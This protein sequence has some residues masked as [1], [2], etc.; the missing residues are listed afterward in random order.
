MLSRRS[1]DELRLWVL[2]RLCPAF[3]AAAEI[4]LDYFRMGPD[5]GGTTAG[6]ALAVVEHRNTITGRH[7]HIHVMFDQQ[8]RYAARANCPDEI[9]QPLALGAVEAGGWFIQQQQFRA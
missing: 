3:E 6:Q 9:D 2:N 7:H 4:G 5:V 8:D 1:R